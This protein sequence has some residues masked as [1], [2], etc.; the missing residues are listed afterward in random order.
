MLRL[1]Y[2]SSLAQ[3]KEPGRSDP[4]NTTQLDGD[5]ATDPCAADYRRREAHKYS[6]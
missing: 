5:P 3:A 6:N 2:E 1:P 4:T